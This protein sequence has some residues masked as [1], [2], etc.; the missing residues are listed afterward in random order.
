MHPICF[1]F[2]Y[3]MVEN[4]KRIQAECYTGESEP[5]FYNYLRPLTSLNEGLYALAC[6]KD[7]CCLATLVRSFKLIEVYVEHGVTALDC[8]IR[9]PRFRATIKDITDKSGSIAANRTEKILLLTSHESSEPTKEP[10]CDSVTSS[11]LPQHDSSTPYVG[12]TQDLIVVEV[13]TQEPIVADVSTR[14]LIVEE[15]ETQVFTVEDVILKDYVSYGG[16]VVQG[17]GQKDESAPNDGQFFYDDEGI[18]TAYETEYDV[19]ISMNLPFDN[20]GITNLVTDDV[21]EGDDVDVI[22]SGGF[23]SDPGNDDETNDYRRRKLAELNREM[24]GVINA[25]GQWEV[26][27][28]IPVKAVQDQLQRDLEVHISM[29]KAFRAKAK[30]E[31]EIKRDHIIQ[32]SMLRDYV[33]SYSDD[34]DLH[35]NLNFAF[36]CDRQ[37]RVASAI[38]IKEFE[39]CMLELKTVNP[40]AHEWLN[41]MPPEHWARSHFLGRAKSDLLLNNIC[42]V[43][44]GKIVGGRDK[45]VIILLKYI[46]EYC[47]KRIMT[48][49]S[50]IEKCIG[51][52]THIATRITESIKKDPLGDQVSGLLGDRCVVD[53]VNKICSCRKWE[54]TGIPCK[55][56][57]AACWNMALNDRAAP[58]SEAWVGR[59][60][61]KIK[62]SKHEDEPFVKDGGNNVESNG[63]AFRQAQQK[64]PAAGQD[65]SCRSGAGVVIGLSAVV[66]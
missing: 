49:Q 36:I 42:E 29:S 21:F 22:N 8:Y 60:R 39:K 34:I 47:M 59:P 13:I 46:R 53:V 24:K 3:I 7:V 15:V 58:P 40:K 19:H 10:I 25:S 51:P 18:D 5:L 56:V 45:P 9:P 66:G 2:E 54:L 35:P 37:K 55:H 6:E 4:F 65:G 44:N 43:F 20:I 31:R 1:R 38:S 50:V 62:R 64:E 26:N 12:R 48:V 57:V 17:N 41:N 27:L 61:K 11:S 52:L 14:V 63:S 33:L 28:D 30:V 16:D 23:D 32:Y